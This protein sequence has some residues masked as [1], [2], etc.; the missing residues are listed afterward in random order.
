MATAV[1]QGATGDAY[2]DGLL[3]GTS[4]DGSFAFGFP[5]NVSDS[6]TAPV[7]F[8]QREA[9]RGIMNGTAFNS[10]TY[11]TSIN[12]LVALSGIE[13][14]GLGSGLAGASSIGLGTFLSASSTAYAYDQGYDAFTAEPSPAD[15]NDGRAENGSGAT[16]F[17]VSATG[18]QGI[19]GLLRGNGWAGGSIT[20]SDPTAANQYQA[21]HD[22]LFTNFQHIDAQQIVAMHFALNAAQYTQP[23]GAAGFS[24]EG[25]TNLSVTY[26]G[27]NGTG[28][29]R[30]ANTSNPGTAY[31]YYPSNAVEGG[32][33]FFGGSGRTPVM[34]DYDWH[35]VLHELGHSLGLKHGQETDIFGAMPSNVDSMEFSVMTYRSYIGAPLSGYTNE[36][37]GYAQTYMM[38]D[39]AALQHMYGADYSTNSGNTTYTW[40]PLNGNTVVNGLATI[41]PGGNRIFLT[42]WDGGGTDTYDMSAY[43]SDLDIDLAAGGY[44]DFNSARA[45]IWAAGRTAGMPAATCS[46][47][48]CI[49]ATP[50]R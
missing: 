42:I 6:T 32:D 27:A 29:I 43:S 39:I 9:A 38:Y 26:N 15:G 45:P 5:Q 8:G 36:Q 20:Y 17:A 7:S 44:S 11:L 28:T 49:W 25:F 37:Y 19:D 33:A 46:T 1:V 10:S 48:S 24:V 14:G 13:V 3:I 41:T 4:W 22:E 18:N 23:A 21:G 2:I 50:P 47:R 16:T 30:L 12:S 34:G 35:T 31:A 40:N